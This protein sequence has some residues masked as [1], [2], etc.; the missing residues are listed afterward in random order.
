VWLL[1]WCI[2][3]VIVM[4]VKVKDGREAA[5]LKTRCGGIY[6]LKC[7]IPASIRPAVKRAL[8][9]RNTGNLT[10]KFRHLA[11]LPDNWDSF[12]MRILFIRRR[13]LAIVLYTHVQFFRPL[14]ILRGHR[15]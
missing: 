14:R 5:W 2:Y 15:V 6:F 7:G 1:I 3:T 13:L 4:E 11:T 10:K 8:A 12:I 9:L